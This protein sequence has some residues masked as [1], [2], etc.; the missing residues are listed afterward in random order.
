M[1]VSKQAGVRLNL[2]V[3]G[4][5]K[6]KKEKEKKSSVLIQTGFFIFVCLLLFFAGV[7]NVGDPL[8]VLFQC[9]LIQSELS[10]T[11]LLQSKPA[12]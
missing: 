12:P 6:K 9:G 11:N 4:S 3:F 2:F 8:F 1:S 7:S 5:L 10:V